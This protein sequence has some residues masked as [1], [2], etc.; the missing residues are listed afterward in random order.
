MPARTLEFLLR[1]KINPP[2]NAES[3]AEQTLEIELGGLRLQLLPLRSSRRASM[4]ERPDI[5]DEVV[6]ARQEVID[7]VKMETADGGVGMI[8]AD[9]EDVIPPRHLQI[10]AQP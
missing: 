7:A 3:T 10:H 4:A 5:R 2:A 9:P 1:P 8:V 6:V